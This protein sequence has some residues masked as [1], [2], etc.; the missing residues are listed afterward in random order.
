[1]L[2][3]KDPPT[4]TTSYR[5]PK[6][7]RLGMDFLTGKSAGIVDLVEGTRLTGRELEA[8]VTRRSIT[9]YQS[10]VAER[11]L[12]AILHGGSA[13]FVADLFAVWACGATA[14]CLD[15]TLTPSE[16]RNLIS[17]MR[18]AAT[19]VRTGQFTEQIDSGNT[20]DLS[21]ASEIPGRAVTAQSKLDDPA[22]LLFTS[23]TSG[24]PKGVLLSFRAILARTS[25]NSEVI[26]RNSLAKALVT[27]PMHFGH[28]LIGNLLTPLL[29]G[30]TVFIPPLGLSLARSL[31]ELIDQH[32]VTFL[33]S[34]PVFWHLVLRFSQRPRRGT[35]RRVHVGSSPLSSSLWRDIADWAGCEVVNCYG[36]TETSNWIGGASSKDGFTD[37]KVG[38]VWGGHAAIRRENGTLCVEGE[39]EI[40]VQTPSIMLSYL[41]QPDLTE[42]VLT[43]GWYRTG[44]IGTV[45]ESGIIT[46]RGRAKD[47][48]N[49]AGFKIQPAEIDSLLGGHPSIE[50]AC[51]FREPDPVSGDIVSIAVRLVRDARETA[52]SLRAWCA[53]R[54]RKQAI[55]ERWYFVEEIP[56]T[57]RGKVSREEVCQY[58]ARARESGT[59]RSY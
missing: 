44:D 14:A 21:V 36:T 51:C 52:E 10:G 15:P 1:M 3:A 47:E 11:S 29:S 27:L 56:R 20:I 26:G 5:Y 30:G 42:S 49:R 22:L 45:D 8:E 43:N 17:F 33:T 23:G 34:V 24:S 6:S 18:P 28:G 9:L 13:Q 39:G 59:S 16:L 37:G 4:A 57:S 35:L 32:A 25:L 58:V 19:L 41:K 7:E 40:A 48:I 53:E 12:V 46:L 2:R 31:A 38:R 54:I 55:P 50:E